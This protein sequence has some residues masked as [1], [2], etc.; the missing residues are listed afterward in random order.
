MIVMKCRFT[1]E[2]SEAVGLFMAEKGLTGLEEMRES[3]VDFENRNG[4]KRKMGL[5]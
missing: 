3:L 5:S 4:E 1:G 2:R